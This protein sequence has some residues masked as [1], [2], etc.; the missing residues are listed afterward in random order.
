MPTLLVEIFN[1]ENSE[2]AK[3]IKSLGYGDPELRP[4]HVYLYS[5]N[6]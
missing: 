3:Y 2:V 1:F 4:E 5:F 6:Q